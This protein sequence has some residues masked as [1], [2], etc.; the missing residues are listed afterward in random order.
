MGKF[1]LKACQSICPT[2]SHNPSKERKDSKQISKYHV[3]L[4][5]LVSQKIELRITQKTYEIHNFYHL[6][7][8]SD[9][10]LVGLRGFSKL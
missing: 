2:Q 1:N 6:P 9:N 8:P 7:P 4:S 10:D 5:R 3:C